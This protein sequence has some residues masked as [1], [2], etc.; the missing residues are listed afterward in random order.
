[1]PATSE[2]AH[3]AA[4]PLFPRLGWGVGLRPKHY[5]EI[6]ERPDLARRVDWFEAI[7]ENFMIRG[8]RPLAVLER[9]RETHP[10]V[11]HG[12][13]L[14]IGSADPLD[15]AYLRG[16]RALVDRFR[17]AIVSDHLCWGS[18][19]G[20]F[21]HDLLPL[22]YHR[23]EV[24]RIADRI[25][26]VQDRIGRRI[27]VENVSSYL[28]WRHSTM[29]EW[30]FVA[31]VAEA[32]DCGI[33][34][35]VNNV[36][37][38]ANNHRFDPVTY[39]QA[40]PVDRVGQFH[41]AGHSDKQRYLFDTHDAPVVDPVWDLYAQAV[42]RFG[43]VSTLI[44]WD[45]KLPTFE[46]LVEESDRAR[47]IAARTRAAGARGAREPAA[48]LVPVHDSPAP[49]GDF[50]PLE[51]QRT[52][53][54]LLTAPEGPGT[55]P[56]AAKIDGLIVG[57]DLTA[58]ERAEIYANMYFAR[59]HDALLE[60]FPALEAALG[61]ARFHNLVTDY[62]WALP[63]EHPSLRHLGDRFAGFLRTHA[64]AAELP[65]A[66]DLAA[67][68]S[69]RV[70]AFDAPDAD[71]IDA[72]ALG[73]VPPDRWASLR[74][75]VHPSASVLPASWRVDRTWKQVE[76]G[77]PTTPPD[78]ADEGGAFR[79]WREGDASA[80]TQDALPT[81]FVYHLWMDPLEGT[82]FP[83]LRD[84]ATFGALCEE[85]TAHLGGDAE[86][87]A[88]AVFALLKNWLGDGLITGLRS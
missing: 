79:V 73:Q 74:F 23:S 48:P 86:A 87:A 32:A 60:D 75:D 25:R 42:E 41:L 80:R 58:S 6:L 64:L 24:R 26:H 34:L 55:S 62:V 56:A 35:D 18:V 82:L 11:L 46:R 59:L 54:Q 1:M 50:S 12:V 28:D 19:D 67:L 47:E 72:A 53:W 70:V 39:L 3:P 29:P 68:E 45:D 22:P 9:I 27:L 81:L 85:A 16:L 36:Y 61:H 44:E 52:F 15:E 20:R 4:A 33:L 30:E 2:T 49:A 51:L 10:I 43:P 69:A 31:A 71:A 88:H 84:G 76:D 83:M 13:S 65:W 8:G 38:S 37:V 7:S 63:S 21:A 57:D 78:P 66:A 14:S 77:E 17:P 40:I 5:P